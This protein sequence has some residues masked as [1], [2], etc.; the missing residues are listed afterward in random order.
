MES[1]WEELEFNNFAI[2]QATKHFIFDTGESIDDL[3]NETKTQ[4]LSL[5]QA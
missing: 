2:K 4:T 1:H 3:I 5:N